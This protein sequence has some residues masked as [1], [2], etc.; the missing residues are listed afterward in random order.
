M[1]NLLISST[2]TGTG[3]S[4]AQH[5]GLTSEPPYWYQWREGARMS[6]TGIVEEAPDDSPAVGQ[7][8]IQS[9]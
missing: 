2:R 9:R 7:T 8:Q 5:H 3:S 6:G 4:T 1:Q